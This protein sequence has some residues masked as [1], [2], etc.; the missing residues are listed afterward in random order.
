MICPTEKDPNT[1]A[2]KEVA[3]ARRQSETA[4]SATA[5]AQAAIWER[6]VL[7]LK[8]RRLERELKEVSRQ[9]EDAEEARAEAERKQVEELETTHVEDVVEYKGSDEFKN[10]VL[11]A[12]VEEP[13]GWEK[14]VA[15]FNPE[16]DINFDISGVPPPI[17]LSRELLFASPSSANPTSP[18]NAE[19]GGGAE[20]SGGG[21]IP[22][23]EL[24]AE[25]APEERADA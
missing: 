16:L 22:E 14:L 24:A 3:L 12:M 9:L 19:L 4:K 18:P 1:R 15:R 25:E 21:S 17:P 2:E 13:F 23:A 11:D 20:V 6:N 5:E 8:V 10:L 7:Q